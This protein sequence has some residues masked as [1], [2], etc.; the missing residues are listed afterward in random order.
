MADIRAQFLVEAVT[1]SLA[2]GVAGIVIGMASSWAISKLA[3]WSTRISS[4]AIALA[5]VFSAL[6]GIFFGWYPARQ[7]ARLDPIT[8]L[9]Y[10]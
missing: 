5:F 2:G 3:D 9:R 6:V 4:S 10:E 8:S 7:A 1:L